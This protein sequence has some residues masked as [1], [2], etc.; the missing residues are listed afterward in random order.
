MTVR[1]EFGKVAIA[2]SLAP[3]EPWTDGR[4]EI[5]G[6]PAR[7]VDAQDH[8]SNR[9][10]SYVLVRRR[11]IHSDGRLW[12]GRHR[13]SRAWRRAMDLER[14]GRDDFPRII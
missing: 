4:V 10:V 13:L 9:K 12:R 2:L 7:I 14:R 6:P 11:F 3:P 8:A 5:F 1:P